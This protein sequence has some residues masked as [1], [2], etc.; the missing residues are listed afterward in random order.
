MVPIRLK[1]ENFR[2]FSSPT[3]IPLD[4]SSLFCIV[5]DNG[6]GKSS[7]VEAM[8]WAL[9]G[10]S[11]SGYKAKD[12]IR[13]GKKYV[14]VSF[15]FKMWG[16]RYRMIRRQNIGSGGTLKLLKMENGEYI[17][18]TKSRRK[19][20]VQKMILKILGTDYNG[21][22]LA[23]VF[24]QNEASLFSTMKPSE[25]RQN[26]AKILG[27]NRFQKLR[28][29]AA[30]RMK[31][32][33][34][35]NEAIRTEMEIAE[36][37]LSD[38]NDPAE[39]IL[40]ISAEI[41][42]LRNE[43]DKKSLQM[44]EIEKRLL[45]LEDMEKRSKEIAKSIKSLGAEKENLE[46]SLFETKSELANVENI[47]SQRDAIL[48]QKSEYDDLSKAY[49]KMSS[50]ASKFFKFRDSLDSAKDEYFRKKTEI[51]K[52]KSALVAKIEQI[53]QQLKNLREELS[54]ADNVKAKVEQLSA[55]KKMLADMELKKEKR[56]KLLHRREILQTKIDEEERKLREQI[57]QLLGEN[58]RLELEISRKAQLGRELSIMSEKLVECDEAQ[59][60]ANSLR[61]KIVEIEKKL[62]T[63]KQKIE[64]IF[65]QIAEKQE[66]LAFVKTGKVARCPRCGSELTGEHKKELLEK[67][68]REISG[69]NAESGKIEGEIGEHTEQANK[70]RAQMNTLEKIAKNG[71]NFKKGADKLSKKLAQMEVVSEQIEKNAEQISKIEEELAGKK[72]A[73]KRRSEIA[74]INSEIGKLEFFDDALAQAQKFVDELSPF[75]RRWELILDKRKSAQKAERELETMTE[76]LAKIERDKI[77][78]E[79]SQKIVNLKSQLEKIPYDSV[80][81]DRIRERLKKLKKVP[82]QYFLLQKAEEQLPNLKSGLEKLDKNLVAKQRELEK[83]IAESEQL[84]QSESAIAHLRAQKSG[85]DA[86]IAEM[87][88]KNA[89]LHSQK[90]ELEMR[91]KMR[92]EMM[93]EKRRLSAEIAQ[94]R[95]SESLF[96]NIV[97]ICGPL[98]IQDWLLR[99]YLSALEADANEILELIC[100][101]ALSVRLLP[102]SGEKLVVRISDELGER[103]YSTYSG[104]EEFRIDFAMRLALSRLLA[105]RSG[106][107]LRTLIIDEGFGSQDETGLEKL[108]E[109]LYDV[110][111]QFDRIIV[112]THLPALRDKFPAKIVVKKNESGSAVSVET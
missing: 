52:K 40:K 1:L 105:N 85:L 34:S 99:R 27:I 102:E 58:E 74:R 49:N 41:G 13:T 21:L 11:R 45:E 75:E 66:Q 29:A 65:E 72:F 56:D 19:S 94:F 84:A 46:K 51:E 90:I 35:K 17:P 6:A 26:L 82:E 28:D 111:S 39:E 42:Q 5:G 32:V 87:D 86:Q 71:V 48:Q 47:I 62:S 68:A 78:E 54:D 37:K 79:L 93:R 100:D 23:T 33:A 7:I 80:E 97:E 44:K 2:S 101:G 109:T 103:D 36:K 104:G 43:Q 91:G 25:R 112:I 20:D 61:K 55:A 110:Q 95:K 57:E 96:K 14:E 69:L 64:N 15:D 24:I 98:G 70:L 30:Q 53:R 106:F 73:L 3:D 31:D 77:L 92:E 8:L 63:S 67:L 22:K 50:L 12:I 81:H 108:V 10:A 59:E 76:E 89:N 107:P 88:E 83:Y 38:I 16:E 4:F 60:K 18:M 9:F